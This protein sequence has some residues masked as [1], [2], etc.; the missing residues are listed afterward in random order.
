MLQVLTYLGRA[1]LMRYPT[2]GLQFLKQL[3]HLGRQNTQF[4][5]AML[6]NNEEN[7][8]KTI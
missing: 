1:F 4:F 2:E 3:S 7:S 8:F 6:W 5:A